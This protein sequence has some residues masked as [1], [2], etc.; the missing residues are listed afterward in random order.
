[1]LSAGLAR[2]QAGKP[3]GEEVPQ[4]HSCPAPLLPNRLLP[5]SGCW[6]CGDVVVSGMKRGAVL[7]CGRLEN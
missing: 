3:A 4:V 6:A 7:Q 1:M 2:H 5:A